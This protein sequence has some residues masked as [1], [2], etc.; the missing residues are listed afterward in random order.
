[1]DDWVLACRNVEEVAGARCMGRNRKTLRE[2]VKD[3][4]E[5]L[6]FQPEWAIFID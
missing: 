6:G 1:M 3:D 4:M 5:V 2:C